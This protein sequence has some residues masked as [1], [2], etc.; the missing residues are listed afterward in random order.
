MSGSR[1]VAALLAAGVLLFAPLALGAPS[2]KEK[3]EAKQAWTKGKQAAARKKWD[4]AVALYRSANDLDPKAQYQLDLGRALVESGA[5]VEAEEVLSGVADTKEPNTQKA[6]AVASKLVKELGGRI[7]TLKV[8]VKGDGAEQAKVTV[9]GNAATPGADLRYDP[10]KHEIVARAPNGAEATD[11]VT[12]AEKENATV[13]LTLVAPVKTELAK[14]E[15]ASSGGT[16]VPAGIAYGVGGAGLAV[17][18]AF[19]ILAFQK[20]DEVEELCG[21]TTCPQ[22]YADEVAAAQDYGTA[23]TVAF[24]IGGLGVVAGLILTFTVGMD[25]GPS[26]SEE[27]KKG[28]RVTPVVGPGF[29]GLT[30]VY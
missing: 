12:L 4:D 21:G 10:G 17:G 1:T 3:A 8:E 7:P 16:M 28:A 2:V 29:V 22:E 24:A 9:D 18:A 30:G 19:G 15:E 25:D 11:S 5:L 13:T 26:E 23:S 14:E 6:K 20:T 27:E